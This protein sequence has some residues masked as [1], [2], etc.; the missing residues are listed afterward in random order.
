MRAFNEISHYDFE[1]GR[2]GQ[3]VKEIQS[4]GK[5]YI[6]KVD[7]QE[8]IEYL[9]QKYILEPL[10]I[11]DETESFDT[12]R[13]SKERINDDRYGRSPYEREAYHFTIKYNYSGSEELFRV[14]SNPWTLT[15][16]DID[17]ESRTQIVS[18]SFKI[19]NQDAEEFLKIK[20]Q[21]YRNAFANVE[22]INKN[23]SEF[24]RGLKES[25]IRA[26]QREKEK[27][28]KENDFFAA[29]NIKVN[30]DT[31]SVFTAPTITK[32]II[33][34]PI[35][36]K[37]KEFSSEPM[38]STEMYNDVLTVIYDSGKNMEKKPALYIGKDEEGLRDQF[39]FVL[40]T[41][42]EGTTAT[43]ETFNRSGKTDIILKY[44]KDGSNLFVAEC[45]FW[46][47]A[48]EFHAAISQLFDRY[49]TWRDSKAALIMFVKNKEF[50]NVLKTIQHE[51]KDHSLFIKESG[52]KGDSSFSYMFCLPQDKQKHVH[53]EII[54]FH[55][56]K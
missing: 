43:G 8:F 38:M 14:H 41:R 27:Y 12:P 26:F 32:K 39:L 1:N 28:L 4:K 3:I 30:P 11:Y 46:H 15:S 21:C 54:A 17:V 56:D 44:A 22:N 18:F 48:S 36:S 42:Y 16:Y 35:V 49:L 52:K 19:Y 37:S 34:Q 53:F 20:N 5:D 23:V 47:G 29:I 6:L 9:F 13:I 55:Y 2:Q 33:P 40:E 31:K 7:E 51:V 50:S 45:K 24:N 25:I 10:Q